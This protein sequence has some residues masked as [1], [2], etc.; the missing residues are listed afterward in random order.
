MKLTN[1]RVQSRNKRP[2][3]YQKVIHILD[4]K[5][6][7]RLSFKRKIQRNIQEAADFGVTF[8]L[9]YIESAGCV[10]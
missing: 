3:V 7:T 9:N 1:K 5:L 8:S 10:I 6:L 2:N 4:L